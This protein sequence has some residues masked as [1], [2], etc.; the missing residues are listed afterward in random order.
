[1]MPWRVQ[2][3]DEMLYAL[4]KEFGSHIHFLFQPL[5]PNLFGNATL[6]SLIHLLL[7]LQP[8]H[9]LQSVNTPFLTESWQIQQ[10]PKSIFFVSTETRSFSAIVVTLELIFCTFLFFD[11]LEREEVFLVSVISNGSRKR[12]ASM[13]SSFFS[14][15]HFSIHSICT[16]AIFNFHAFRTLWVAGDSTASLEAIKAWTF[17]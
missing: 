1:M 5:S 3:G 11:A 15:R 13:G 16:T 10:Q 12:N 2:Y 14:W 8:T 17:L 9:H 4:I 6:E 7:T